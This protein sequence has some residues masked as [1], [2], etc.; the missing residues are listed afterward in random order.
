[1]ENQNITEPVTEQEQGRTFTQEQV[2]AIVGKRLAEQKAT[3]ESD[4]VKREDELNKREMGIRA[5][6]LLAEKGLPKELA[7][8]LRYS[9][10]DELVKAIN[11]IEHTRGFKGEEQGKK[12]KIIENRL[13]IGRNYEPADPI[14][15]AF[16]RKDN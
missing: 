14:A 7:D 1:M 2:N 9:N 12:F 15:N 3:M 13:P 6:E 11:T 16:K 5:K 8:V 4:F 10:E